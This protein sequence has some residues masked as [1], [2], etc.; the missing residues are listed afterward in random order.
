MSRERLPQQLVQSPDYD[1]IA[2]DA[3]HDHPQATDA[4]LLKIVMRRER[5]LANPNAVNAAITR[6]RAIKDAE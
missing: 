4:E 5:G 1:T 3:L 2:S 6:Q